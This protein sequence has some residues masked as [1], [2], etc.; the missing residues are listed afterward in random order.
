MY[1][2]VSM[3]LLPSIICGRPVEEENTVYGAKVQVRGINSLF[4]INSSNFA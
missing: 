4:R 1:L 3:R 2:Q